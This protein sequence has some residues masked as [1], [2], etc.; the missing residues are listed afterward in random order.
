MID[1]IKSTEP[2][3][4][5]PGGDSESGYI[6]S[7][8]EDVYLNGFESWDQVDGALLRFMLTGPLHWLGLAELGR[9]AGG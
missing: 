3:F 2:D 5:R 8:R 6:R 7:E 9:S 4:Q 1:E